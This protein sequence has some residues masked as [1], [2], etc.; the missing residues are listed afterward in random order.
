MKKKL[1]HYFSVYGYKLRLEVRHELE[2]I[3]W[4]F[5]WLLMIPL[6]YCAGFYVLWVMLEQGGG[7]NGWGSGEAA[8]LF[9]LSMFSHGLQDLFFIRTRS[10]DEL[11]RFGELDRMLLM[12]LGLFG[13]F[14]MIGLNICGLYD[15]IPAVLLFA[16]GCGQVGFV[17]SAGNIFG[18]LL[19]IAGGT[20]ISLAFY[21]V[22][23]CLAFWF[24]K[25]SSL[26]DLNLRLIEKM[27]A[28]PLTIYPQALQAV[29][30]FLVP[31]GFISFYPACGF[32]GMDSGIGRL[33]PERMGNIFAGGFPLPAETPLMS[34]TV[35]AVCLI[36]ARAVFL[37]TLKRRYDGSGSV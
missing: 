34:L 26:E 27:T 22:T 20:M 21:T 23:G 19:V 7:L 31:L 15:L 12:P 1:R 28:Y 32:L 30:S 29:F 14:C 36:I 37:F 33:L 2:D 5:C 13:Q 9:G 17:W 35:G 10:V 24:P 6:S 16:W 11:I 4:T 8:F 25:S 3:S 18:V